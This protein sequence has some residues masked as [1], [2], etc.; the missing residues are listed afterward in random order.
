MRIAAAVFHLTLVAGLAATTVSCAR[1]TEPRP[2]ADNARP[3]DDT[4]LVLALGATAQVAPGL[5][6]TFREVEQ[7]SRCPTDVTCVT[8]G[9]VDVWLKVEADGLSFGPVLHLNA[10]P[11][12]AEL[13]GYV[14]RL[15]GLQPLPRSTHPTERGAYIATITVARP[16]R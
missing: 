7:D 3:A 5:R 12:T 4:T 1:S 11:R 13:G 6:V 14:V 15:S 10:E 9:D 8:A 16:R 2:R